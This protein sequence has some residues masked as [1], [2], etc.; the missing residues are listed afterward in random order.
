MIM[1]GGYGAGVTDTDGNIVDPLARPSA[2][3][4]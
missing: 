2:T 3:G 1:K 4:N